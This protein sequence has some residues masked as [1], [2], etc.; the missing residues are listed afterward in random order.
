MAMKSVVGLL[1]LL[2]VLVLLGI[3]WFFPIGT[4][5]FIIVNQSNNGGNL[6]YS[7]LQ[8]Y[9][10]MRFPENKISYRIENCPLKKKDD[11]VRAFEMIEEIS[12]L[13]FYVSLN[14]EISITCDST[15]RIEEGLFIAG[16]GGP[17]NITQAENFNVINSGSILLLRESS[18]SFPNIAVH[19]LLH[20]LG[21]DHTSNENDIM[22]PISSCSQSITS[23]TIQKLNELYSIPSLPDLVIEEASGVMHG[24]YLDV[25]I[26]LRNN[27][28]K[29]SPQTEIKVFAGDDVVKEL[30]VDAL[31]VGY[32]RIISLTNI[33]ISK[34]SVDEIKI[35]IASDFE[36]L[37]KE[38]NVVILKI[39]NKS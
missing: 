22:Y 9:K 15:A 24:K 37:K 13:N 25:N 23:E 11:M 31:L 6:S 19:E 16:E 36:E 5:E 4:T 28:L 35:E 33:W 2:I 26:S 34:L 17:T 21:F 3:Y 7:T 29:A 30:N 14:P 32:G 18:C 12:P 1:F 27:G 10:N 38:N 8:F 20:V 39:K